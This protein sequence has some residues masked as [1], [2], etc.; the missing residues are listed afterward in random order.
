MNSIWMLV[1]LAMA[2]PNIEPATK[3][4]TAS[5]I[6]ALLDEEYWSRGVIE[7]RHL[8]EAD[9]VNP[10]S[11]L[12]LGDAL[13][14]Y[15]NDGGNLYA[16]FDAWVTAKKLSNPRSKIHRLAEARLSW[17][18]E[19]SGIVKLEPS[20][21]VGVDG[22]PSDFTV[23]AF[24]TK[25]LDW[26][27]RVDRVKGGVYITN[28]PPGPVVLKVSAGSEMP[29]AVFSLSLEAGDFKK[30]T[31]ATDSSAFEQGVKSGTFADYD[32]TGRALVDAQVQSLM[33]QPHANVER[34]TSEM[35]TLPIA[36]VP[37]DSQ[38]V[39][40]SAQ[41]ER[42][43]YD[44]GTR[45]TLV[46]GRYTVAVKKS[47]VRD[48]A[49]TYAD[50]VVHP[51][52]SVE[53]IRDLVLNDSERRTTFVDPNREAVP[54]TP[55]VENSSAYGVWQAPADEELK[56]GG[57]SETGEEAGRTTE[58][59]EQLESDES[60]GPE[61]DVETVSTEPVV[62][63]QES[64]S[65]DP[66]Q[67]AEEEPST[68]QEF[69]GTQMS[70]EIQ[71]R[72]EQSEQSEQTKQQAQELSITE[73]ASS[74][75]LASVA[76]VADSFAWDPQVATTIERTTLAI[77]AGVVL[78]TGFAMLRADHFADLANA[79]VGS[80]AQFEEYS[81]KSDQWRSIFVLSSVALGNV[82][83]FYVGSKWI[84]WWAVQ[85]GRQQTDSQ[86]VSEPM[87]TNDEQSQSQSMG[88]DQ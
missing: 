70:E 14:H 7:A 37:V 63:T 82:G 50:I 12:T 80:Q 73:T 26:T 65:I 60:Q 67:V 72:D 61:T 40:V 58:V 79:E 52:L 81:T 76:D 69:D 31:V 54:L 55:S 21:F 28:I 6:Y 47:G 16:A 32:Q 25:N 39:F 46:G 71:G 75:S 36:P 23:T 85:K 27:P 11:H 13:S 24:A 33:L 49:V 43:V 35:V 5:E 87:S 17:A 20:S 86:E 1:S 19:R 3:P 78:G 77:G 53:T 41:G 59:S 10:L 64:T 62:S 56:I 38:T 2:A 57:A 83:S 84:E 8:I 66:P 18:L 34:L 88:G 44:N 30:R 74:E 22:F 15:P 42:I 45:Q 4:L 48:G 51:D 9:P 29:V 68:V